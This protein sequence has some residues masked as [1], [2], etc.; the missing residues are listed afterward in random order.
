MSSSQP[1]KGEASFFLVHSHQANLQPHLY[2]LHCALHFNPIPTFLGVI[3]NRTLSFFKPASLLK[4]KC[5][6]QFKVLCCISAFSWGPSKESLF[7]LYKVL[8]WPFLSY[9]SSGWFPFLSVTKLEHLHRAAS[10]AITNCRSSC[11]YPT[12]PL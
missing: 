1:G 11:P 8:L 5:F 7:L 10:R 6:S 3:I 2:L 4:A 9:G 12:S